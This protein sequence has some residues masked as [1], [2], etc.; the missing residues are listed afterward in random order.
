MKKKIN[1]IERVEGKHKINKTQDLTSEFVESKLNKQNATADHIIPI[2][3]GGNNCQVN[4]V[5]CCKDC[6]NERGNM[7]FQTYLAIKKKNSKG[8]KLFI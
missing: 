6:N 3:D 4:L 1:I 2:S 8:K 5:V 7:D